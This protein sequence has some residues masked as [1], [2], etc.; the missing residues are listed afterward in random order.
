VAGRN[1]VASVKPVLTRRLAR[2]DH[3]SLMASIVP[4][5]PAFAILLYIDTP[6]DRLTDSVLYVL[7]YWTLWCSCQSLATYLVFGR[8]DAATFAERIDSSRPDR[9]TA[10]RL[11]LGLDE[12]AVSLATLLSLV[13]V[14]VTMFVFFT[15]SLRSNTAVVA[16]A[17]CSVVSS[18]VLTAFSYTIKYARYDQRQKGLTFPGDETP[19]FSDY[20]YYAICVNATFA[21]SDVTVMS[22]RMRRL[23]TTHT[24]VAFGFNT[25]IFALL[26]TLL[27]GARL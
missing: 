3:R 24:L 14:A 15:P 11:V 10:W 25:V 26:I 18:W 8:C 20:L 27:T 21:T 4:I 13:M 12:G 9:R 5:L 19:G 16:L 23:T 22:R 6:G 2:E 7:T 17:A 1:A